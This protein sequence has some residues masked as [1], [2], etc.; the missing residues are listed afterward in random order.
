[1]DESNYETLNFRVTMSRV[2]ITFKKGKKINYI[3]YYLKF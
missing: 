3:I 1:M 2:L